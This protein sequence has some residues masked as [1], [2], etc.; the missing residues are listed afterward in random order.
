MASP[1]P[2][3]SIFVLMALASVGCRQV[4]HRMVPDGSTSTGPA[5]TTLEV[6]PGNDRL[7][8]PLQTSATRSAPAL[9]ADDPAL[10]TYR[11]LELRTCVVLAAWNSP[12]ANALDVKRSAVSWDCPPRHLGLGSAKAR[13]GRLEA[14]VLELEADEIRNQ[15]AGKA[16]DVF[17]QLARAQAQETIVRRSQ[18][19]VKAALAAATI[20]I[21]RGLP[22][23]DAEIRLRRQDVDLRAK[24]VKLSE[25]IDR[26][27]LA[28]R[29]TLV[30]APADGGWVVRPLVDWQAGPD[31]PEAEDAVSLGLA[32]RPQLRLLRFVVCDVDQGSLPAA[33]QFLATIHPLLRPAAP[34]SFLGLALAAVAAKVHKEEPRA[35]VQFRE[36]ARSVLAWRE[37]AIAA[38]IRDA[39]IAVKYQ[40][41][42]VPVA[43]DKYALH[44]AELKRL[45]EKARRGLTN[46]LE[47]SL[48][49][50]ELFEAESQWLEQLIEL[51]AQEVRLEQAQGLLWMSIPSAQSLCKNRI[52]YPRFPVQ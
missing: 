48:A 8:D 26:L 16:A 18:D 14:T 19:E 6:V 25:T 52:E 30:L 50:L 49:R 34:G 7:P 12:L 33:G 38:E 22:V 40:A 41:H 3:R 21:E 5:A 15:D 32:N 39:A 43:R 28:L 27:S 20:Q 10:R 9:L 44:A 31:I 35:V 46:S 13:A 37:R 24:R 42:Q 1:R 51:R 23:H 36:Q 11:G 47:L 29:E 2:I 4:P 45:E 17:F